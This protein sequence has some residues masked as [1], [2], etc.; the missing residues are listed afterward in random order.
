M[1]LIVQADKGD[2]K[3]DAT[4]DPDEMGDDIQERRGTSEADQITAARKRVWEDSVE[5]LRTRREKIVEQMVEKGII[6]DEQVA[7]KLE[8]DGRMLAS[9]NAGIC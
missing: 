1:L 8:A 4:Q 3:G 7:K 5:T 6:V 2:E 9:A